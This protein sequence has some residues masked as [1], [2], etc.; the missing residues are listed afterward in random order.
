M[1]FD[2]ALFIAAGTNP[3]V[4]AVLPL[5]NSGGDIFD[6]LI[7]GGPG[8]QTDVTTGNVVFTNGGLSATGSG[9]STLFAQNLPFGFSATNPINWSFSASNT[10]T[11][12]SGAPGQLVCNWAGTGEIQWFTSVPDGGSTLA[13][14]GLGLL[15]LR[16]ARR[17]FWHR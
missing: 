17:R 10:P 3:T 7:N 4:T 9:N 8:L 16:E 13:M 6:F 15:G 1:S 14:L 12:C 5:V 11:A 2:L